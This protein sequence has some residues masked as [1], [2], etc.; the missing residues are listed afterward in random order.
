MAGKQGGGHGGK[1][2]HQEASASAMSEDATRAAAGKRPRLLK[3]R[4]VSLFAEVIGHGYPVVLMHGG[5]S[6]DHFTL[7]P[8]RQ[9]ADRF[10]LV[11]YDHRCSG[12]SGTLPSRP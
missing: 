1:D 7:G 9:L 4:D 11:F 5:P 3:I 2:P 6:L 8:F 10:T 12:R